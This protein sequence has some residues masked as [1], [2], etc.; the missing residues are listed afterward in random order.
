MIKREAILQKLLDLLDDLEV[1]EDVAIPAFRSR[2]RAFKA[3]EV[4]AIVI[5][6]GQDTP[7]SP[8]MH[9]L[10]WSL[11]VQIGVYTRGDTPDSAASDIVGAIHDALSSDLSLGGLVLDIQPGAVS[12]DFDPIDK[13]AGATLLT[14]VFKY[15][16]SQSSL[17]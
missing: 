15:R 14:Y 4:P 2:E 6:P 12:F 13:Q 1:A 5:M 3:N 8:D 17:N 16:T 11:S 10:D 7:S 9:T